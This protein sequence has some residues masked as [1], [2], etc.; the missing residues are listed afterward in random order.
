[1]PPPGYPQR[2]GPGYGDYPTPNQLSDQSRGYGSEYGP[3]RVDGYGGPPVNQRDLRNA[4]SSSQPTPPPPA[5]SSEKTSPPSSGHRIAL[6][7]NSMS[8]PGQPEAGIPPC[9]EADGTP[10]YL[11]SALFERSVFPCKIEVRQRSPP[12]P[13]VSY[14]GDEHPHRGRYDVLPYD[15]VQ[16][17]FVLTSDGRIPQGKR[18]ID[19]GYD[20][21]GDRLYHAVGIVDGLRLPGKT[22]VHL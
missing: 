11:G 9:Y 1:M 10:V 17:E 22:G 16:M 5:Y 7:A 3:G 13:F 18:P 20:E 6:D 2:G 8:F 14:C 19:G 4:S 15:P 21:S 12:K